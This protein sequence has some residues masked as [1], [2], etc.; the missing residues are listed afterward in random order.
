MKHSGQTCL[1]Q[2]VQ[3]RITGCPAAT[4]RMHWLLLS[5]I[6]PTYH[7]AIL[8]LFILLCH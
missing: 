3:A 8:L 7:K 2:S 1:A 4:T 5:S 6:V